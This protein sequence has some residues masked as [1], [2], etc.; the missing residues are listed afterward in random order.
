MKK[1]TFFISLIF[2]CSLFSG[3]FF[4]YNTYQ[5]YFVVQFTP[6]AYVETN[7]PLGNPY[8]G[9]Y[10]LYAYKVSDT[11]T[12]TSKTVREAMGVEDESRL[13]LLLI[14]IN[15]YHNSPISENGLT[16]IDAILK[17]WSQSNKKLILRF[18]YDWDGNGETSEPSNIEQVLEHMT[19]TSALVNTYKNNIYIMQG[20]FVG[21]YGEMHGSKHLEGEQMLT[22]ME[23][24][25]SHTDP[26]IFLS[27]RTPQHWRSII[28]SMEPT[29]STLAFSNNLAARL[30]L[31]NDGMLGSGNDCGTYGDSI[32]SEVVD[33]SLKGTRSEE[34]SFQNKLCL[35]VPNGG[36]VILDNSYND[37]SSALLDLATMHVSYLNSDYD[38]QVLAKWKNTIY[39]E[40]GVFHGSN[41]Y[42]MIQEHLGYRYVLRSSKMDY[43]P[44]SPKGAS[45][46]L[47]IENTGFAN[48]LVPFQVS[49]LL[50]NT[51]TQELTV[52]PIE[53]DI[54][55]WDAGNTHEISYSLDVLRHNVGEYELY[56][57]ITDPSNGE[58][59]RLANEG[60]TENVGYFLGS[61]SIT[62]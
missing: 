51:A 24:L 56:L 54:R 7:S 46:T 31:F 43:A 14:N 44:F 8:Q 6:A 20:I 60:L 34:L 11:S 38:E 49:V 58:I 10:H 50:R 45:F 22:L 32:L 25:S 39:Q 29:T 30:G 9:F 2:L 3:I 53:S 40:S 16:Q 21:N 48:S 4:L 59:I 18:L 13:A 52:A 36:E 57:R 1:R 15:A 27:V 55:F 62:K 26:S 28:K 5:N 35:Y 47:S 23:H 37:L 41:G 19:Q 61:L 42:D 12:Y 17:T 33:Y